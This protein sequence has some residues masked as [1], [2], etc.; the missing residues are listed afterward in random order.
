MIRLH[1]HIDYQVILK[2][3]FRDQESNPKSSWP[4]QPKPNQTKPNF[5]DCLAM[6]RYRWSTNASFS[7]FRM[8]KCDSTDRTTAHYIDIC[9]IQEQSNEIQCC[10]LWGWT[11]HKVT[12]ISDRGHE[13]S[14]AIK[15][16]HQI[17]VLFQ[18]V[19]LNLTGFNILCEKPP[20]FFSHFM[21]G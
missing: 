19:I 1:S 4:D 3:L 2:S 8:R 18:T 11:A 10:F 5:F 14:K 6:E 16:P 21:A 13:I 12:P 9:H 17:S 20:F 15:W 7:L